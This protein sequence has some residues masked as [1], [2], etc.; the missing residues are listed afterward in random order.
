MPIINVVC[1]GLARGRQL[2][3]YWCHGFISTMRSTIW[4]GQPTAHGEANWRMPGNNSKPCRNRCSVLALT[5]GFSLARANRL[6]QDAPRQGH[7]RDRGGVP[8]VYPDRAFLDNCTVPKIFVQSTR[9]EFG[10]VEGTGVR[11]ACGTETVVASGGSRTASSRVR[12]NNE[13]RGIP[14]DGDDPFQVMEHHV[15]GNRFPG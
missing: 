14:A 6:R 4:R 7:A 9:D 11:S 8:T 13:S 10:P 2:R 12:W 5:G 1:I 3:L 15:H